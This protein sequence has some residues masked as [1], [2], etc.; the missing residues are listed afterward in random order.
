MVMTTI[1]LSEKDE[2][3]TKGLL[4]D[5]NHYGHLLSCADELIRYLEDTDRGNRG[6]CRYVMSVKNYIEKDLKESIET[7]CMSD[8]VPHESV[9]KD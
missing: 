6:S 2:I 1:D 7:Y 3:E 9:S 5:L 4:M 8:Y